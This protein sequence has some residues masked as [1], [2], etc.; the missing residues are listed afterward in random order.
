MLSMF[1]SL[2]NSYVE[3]LTPKA[4]ILEGEA[5]G[6]QLFHEIGDFMSGLMPLLEEL[7]FYSLHVMIQ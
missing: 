7:A 5:V 6:K 2:W 3:V 1:V 4:E